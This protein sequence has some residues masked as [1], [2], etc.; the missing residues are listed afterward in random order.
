MVFFIGLYIQF[1]IQ[2]TSLGD[3]WPLIL[4]GIGSAISLPIPTIMS[5]VVPK[6]FGRLS[7]DEHGALSRTDVRMGITITAIAT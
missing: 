2:G 7:G 3:Y 6:F 1:S 4:I 5:S